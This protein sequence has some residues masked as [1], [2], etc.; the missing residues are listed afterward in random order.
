MLTLFDKFVETHKFVRHFLLKRNKQKKRLM[1]I[2]NTSG[3]FTSE[4]FMNLLTL[5]LILSS[6]SEGVIYYSEDYMT[7]KRNTIYFTGHGK[8]NRKYALN[9]TTY[10]IESRFADLSSGEETLKEK[11]VRLLNN[12]FA[13]STILDEKY[14]ICTDEDNTYRE[15]GT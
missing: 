9:N 1:C 6:T 12:E 7:K 3:V 15:G 13:H 10:I 5:W 11:M 8:N 14:I 4:R 2:K